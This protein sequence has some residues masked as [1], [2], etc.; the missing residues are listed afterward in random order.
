[1]KAEKCVICG[2][3]IQ[4]LGNNPRPFVNHGRCCDE[5]NQMVKQWRYMNRH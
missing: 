4:G 3:V 2:A 5:C 1:M